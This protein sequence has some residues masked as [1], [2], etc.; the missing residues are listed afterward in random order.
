MSDAEKSPEPPSD[1]ILA[2]DALG[3]ADKGFH[4]HV[5]GVAIF[6]VLATV[7]IGYG[8]AKVMNW[9]VI[10]VIFILFIIAELAHFYFRVPTTFTKLFK[11]APAS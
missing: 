1:R 3:V 7:A 11:S 6:D 4:K 5:G 8:V 2:P 9:S 10:L